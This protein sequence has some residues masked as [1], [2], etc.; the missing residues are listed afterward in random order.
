[1]ILSGDAGA[2][3]TELALFSDSNGKLQKLCSERFESKDYSSLDVIIRKFLK[4]KETVITSACIGIAGTVI[5]GIGRSTNLPWTLDERLLSREFD[6]PYFRLANDL[7][8]I[9]A[10]VTV[11]EEKDLITIYKGN[12]KLTEGS[13]AIIAPGTGLGQAALLYSDNEY[14]IIATE[15]G[16]SDFAASDELEFELYKYLKNIYGHVSYERIASGMGLV[17]VFKFLKDSYPAKVSE[18]ILQRLN[19]EDEAAVIS[20]E[21]MK[22]NCDLCE[23]ALDIFTSVLGAQAGNMVLNYKATG[24]V[25]LGGGIPLK[26]LEK[27]YDGTFLRSYLNKGRLSYLPEMTP[28]FVIKDRS[29][30]LL[31]AALLSLEYSSKGQD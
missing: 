1:M 20:E 16:H 30:G 31:G 11:L 10:A 29:S 21:G 7:E 22:K 19:N 12:E 14:S 8:I 9:A 18:R 2:T 13:K 15:G 27:F 17:N 25:Y 26:V 6:I 3:K 5:D 28:V 23:K 24:G 4:D